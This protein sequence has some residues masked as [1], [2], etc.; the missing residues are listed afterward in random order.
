MEDIVKQ[1]LLDNILIESVIIKILHDLKRII[2]ANDTNEK[3]LKKL[4][5]QLKSKQNN[6]NVFYDNL[7]S[8][9][10]EFD[11]T[12]RIFINSEQQKLNDIKNEI[13][14]IVCSKQITYK[15][16]GINQ[17]R[18]FIKSVR[19]LLISTDSE[20]TKSFLISL[21]MEVIV[22]PKR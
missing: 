2:R 5:A 20:L 18:N 16:F 11:E 6:L 8:N 15:N 22:Y 12:I 10:V 14:R 13:D 1:S 21:G 3:E 9:K 4:N 19:G 7:L 17:I